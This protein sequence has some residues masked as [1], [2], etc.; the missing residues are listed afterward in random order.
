M[1]PVANVIFPAFFAPFVAQILVP[2]AGLM[3]LATEVIF[4]RWWTGETRISRLLAM[5]LTANVVSS[6]VG[7]FIASQLPTGYA[8]AHS[9]SPHSSWRAAEWS[10]Y[11]ALAWVLAFVISV[12]V[13]WPILVVFSKLVV[14]RRSIIAS[15]FA[16]AC[17]YVMLLVVLFLYA[18]SH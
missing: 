3:A 12:V 18:V 13:E 17:S 5:V 6:T 8:P 11:A 4:Y 10:D 2:V 16:N 15:F 14:V 1:L 7:M 9:T